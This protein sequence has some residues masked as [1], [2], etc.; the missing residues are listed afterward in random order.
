MVGVDYGWL[1]CDCLGVG[2]G[3]VGDV[4]GV[5][6]VGLVVWCECFVVC[7]VGFCLCVVVFDVYWFFFLV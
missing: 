1:E 5:G 4:V 7:L 3:F 6:V 2:G